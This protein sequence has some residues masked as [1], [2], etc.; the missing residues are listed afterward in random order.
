MSHSVNNFPDCFPVY[1]ITEMPEEENEGESH[2]NH[3]KT[4]APHSV[5]AG[6]GVPA[7]RLPCWSSLYRVLERSRG[8]TGH[9]APGPG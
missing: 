6:A 4:P 9:T 3:P 8:H 7:G 5:G 2:A 1:I